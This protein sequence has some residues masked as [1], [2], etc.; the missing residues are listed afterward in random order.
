[1]ATINLIPTAQPTRLPNGGISPDDIARRDAIARALL[2]DA[3]PKQ[4][5]DP[6]Q[7]LAQLS[8][9][10]FG[11][12]VDQK[13][14][15]D[16]A[17]NRNLIAQ[18]L[19]GSENGEISPDKLNMILA[20][21]PELGAQILGQ[22]RE[23]RLREEQFARQDALRAE[24]RN[25]MIE[26]RADERA[27]NAPVRDAQL[28]GFGLQNDTAALN[29]DQS[30]EGFTPL[31]TPED[32][33]AFGI[34]PTDTSV[35]YKGPDNKPYNEAPSGGGITINT[36][37]GSDATLN[38]KLSEKEGES[39]SGLKDAGMVAGSLGQDLAILDELMTVAP[40]GPIVG[41]LAETF[42]GFS[43]AG[44]AFQSIVKR[45]APSLRT[46][47]SGATSDIEYEGFLQSLP[48]LKNAPEA[49]AMINS[50]MKAKAA[51][52]VK[53]SDIVTAYQNGEITV[54][55]ARAKL[56]ELNKISIVTPDMK[57]ALLGVG[58]EN[59]GGSA[60]A[61][62]QVGEV[63]DGFVYL[64]GDPASPTSWRQQQ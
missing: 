2:E 7:G 50:I 28:R 64:G 25:W 9:A 23:D 40:Q 32:R 59:G 12:M 34:A 14:K 5:T 27:Y 4:I 8:D 46:P 30:R 47:G 11:G 35:W 37:D 29:L 39:W 41:P 63:V 21:D 42:K 54:S 15:A 51:L 22:Q 45:V 10:F 38:K 62:P 31:V 49:N 16:Q 17:E 18:A 55:E 19:G 52:N 48:A 44:D 58:V 57:K 3:K 53:R 6:M 43:S 33:A 20:L 24:D 26:D 56:A 36:G 13:V 60:P 1:M 61:A